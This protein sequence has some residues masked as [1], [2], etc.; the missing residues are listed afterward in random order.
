VNFFLIRM[1]PD[2]A[3]MLQVITQHVVPNPRS[4]PDSA[5]DSTY[6]DF[7]KTQPPIFYIA[8][9]PLEAEDWICTLEQKF[10]LIR[11]SDV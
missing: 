10:S 11:C 5:A 6:L 8:N 2:S 3:R 9:E 1:L 7:L 4:R